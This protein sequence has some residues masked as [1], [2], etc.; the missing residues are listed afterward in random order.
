MTECTVL[1]GQQGRTWLT[2]LMQVDQIP[3]IAA[4][5][6]VTYLNHMTAHE[7]NEEIPQIRA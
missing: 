4:P 5:F 1:P 3:E 6:A 2:R 7:N